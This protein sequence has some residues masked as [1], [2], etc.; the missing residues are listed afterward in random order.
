M[1]Q[2]ETGES[3]P[4]SFRIGRFSFGDARSAQN[5][6]LGSDRRRQASDL[7]ACRIE[8][9]FVTDSADG[10][11]RDTRRTAYL[12]E[13]FLQAQRAIEDG[14]PLAGYFVWSLLD[15]FEW[16]HGYAQRFGIVWVDLATQRRTL[17]DSAL[18]YRD[19]IAKNGV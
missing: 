11:I 9:A 2:V 3:V 17:K 4:P 18:W 15:N 6:N 7:V 1:D 10:R 19:A 16:Q 14:V 8:R 12:R 5:Q 13:H